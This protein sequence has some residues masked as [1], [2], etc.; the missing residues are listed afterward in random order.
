MVHPN[1]L[2]T[3]FA[4]LAAGCTAVSVRPVDPSVPLRHV[5]IENN[6]AVT[7]PDFVQVLRDGFARHHIATQVYS[8][9]A[10]A[11]CETILRYTARRSWDFA[12]YLS[13]AALRLETRD[14][15]QLAA[16]NYHLRA[17]G[18]FSLMKWQSV[19]TK[20]DPVIDALL[21]PR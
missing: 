16:A 14:G 12:S 15:A 17:K 18:G 13:Q 2:A 8:G 20:M 21:A 7:I 6:P 19:R 10:P 4:V 9:E 11:T 5:C 3:I 1:R